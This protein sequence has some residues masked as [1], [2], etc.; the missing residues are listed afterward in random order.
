V[1]RNQTSKYLT[2]TLLTLCLAILLRLIGS[3]SI[4]VNMAE[5][6]LF[7][8]TLLI[9]THKLPVTLHNPA[10]SGLTAPL[11]YFLPSSIGVGR[12]WGFVLSISLVFLP[13]ISREQISFRTHILLSFLLAADPLLVYAGIDAAY[14]M[15]AIAFYVWL[16]V[17]LQKKWKHLFGLFFALGLLAGKFFWVLLLLT[18]IYL[19]LVMRK[20]TGQNRS[21]FFAFLKDRF[22]FLKGS[23]ATFGISLICIATA[24][25]LY[26]SGIGNLGTGLV[27]LFQF[28]ISGGQALE[29]LLYLA[30]LSYSLPYLFLLLYTSFA[31]IRGN[32]QLDF[33]GI[34]VAYI[35][36]V[37]SAIFPLEPGFQLLFIFFAVYVSL[38]L[39]Q[40]LL[41][42][43]QPN[44]SAGVLTFF[45]HAISIY[46]TILI[47]NL[48]WQNQYFGLT[49]PS[50]IGLIA[51][52]VLLI[53]A[54]ALVQIGWGRRMAKNG[55]LAAVLILIPILTIAATFTIIG[56]HAIYRSQVFCQNPVVDPDNTI[57]D[58]LRFIDQRA[59]IAPFEQRLVNLSRQTSA[60]D[61]VFRNYDQSSKLPKPDLV[62]TELDEQP[63]ESEA[64]NGMEIAITKH[65]ALDPNY[66]PFRNFINILKG[67]IVMK[68]SRVKIWM[69]PHLIFGTLP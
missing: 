46:I 54:V 25:L 19:V 36:L 52:L 63:D 38:P 37:L 15:L 41:S 24:F 57:G 67:N 51:G 34:I 23:A 20:D 2:I 22:D 45:L 59:G 5:I 39:I 18:A 66:T 4:P 49:L 28:Q 53:L 64:Y 50:L 58:L 8:E 14:P 16:V 40:D 47:H 33:P 65:I 44:F 61:W 30:R 13:F 62:L 9:S 48:G 32:K 11:F 29:R 27:Q 3:K 55:V 35:T 69:T 60:V 10:Y 42:R 68:E 7:N 21:L 12:L 31:F 26:P 43:F 17:A 6:Q 56:P 1:H